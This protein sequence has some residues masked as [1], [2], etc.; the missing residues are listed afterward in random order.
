MHSTVQ[1]QERGGS[2]QKYASSLRQQLGVVN[3]RW[4]MVT[5]TLIACQ[6]AESRCQSASRHSPAAAAAV[7]QHDWKS[8]SKNENGSSSTT[9]AMLSP[10]RFGFLS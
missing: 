3:A 4:S 9:A 1:Q 10:V 7:S 6:P 2:L 8:G 5:A